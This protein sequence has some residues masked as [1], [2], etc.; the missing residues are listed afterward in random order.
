MPRKRVGSDTKLTLLFFKTVGSHLGFY[1]PSTRTFDPEMTNDPLYQTNLDI[2]KQALRSGWA[3]SEMEGFLCARYKA[4]DRCA[5]LSDILPAKAREIQEDDNLLEPDIDYQHPALYLRS[6]PVFYVK[7]G[8][9]YPRKHGKITSTDR[10][11]LSDLVDYY[12]SRMD[13][14]PSDRRRRSATNSLRWL[15]EGCRIDEL[16]TAIDLKCNTMNPDGSP[17]SCLSVGDFLDQAREIVCDLECRAG[18]G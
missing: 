2:V 11:T 10:F 7:D 9:R 13:M 17:G 6:P 18:E 12:M 5:L 8:L 3:E 4:G 1:N 15:L 14:E 16:L